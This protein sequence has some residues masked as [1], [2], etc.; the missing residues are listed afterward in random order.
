MCGCNE[1]IK[2]GLAIKKTKIYT[3]SIH[4]IHHNMSDWGAYYEE[5]Q[6]GRQL[7][8]GR[9]HRRYSRNKTSTEF[10]IPSFRVF[11][12]ETHVLAILAKERELLNLTNN[13][14]FYCVE[15]DDIEAP[16]IPAKKQWDDEDVEEDD[17]K[18]SLT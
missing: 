4:H 11:N 15:N 7:T 17:I 1:K 5:Q 10:I 6:G 16:A 14:P 3:S 2:Y 9:T 18:V 13:I 8:H 12:W